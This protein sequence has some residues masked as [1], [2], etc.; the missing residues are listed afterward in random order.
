MIWQ[1][2][3]NQSDASFNL[4]FPRF[5]RYQEWNIQGTSMASPHVAGVAAL[6]VSRGITNPATIEG[7]LRQT[8]RDLGTPGRDNEFGDGLIQPFA[9]LF[10]LGGGR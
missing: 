5:D 9:A 10:G 3:I 6:L 1:A 2:S 8:A 4:I 7:I